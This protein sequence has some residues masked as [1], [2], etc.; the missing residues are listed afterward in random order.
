MFTVISRIHLT[1][2]NTTNYPIALSNGKYGGIDRNK[3][4]DRG[5]SKLQK[6]NCGW[7]PRKEGIVD[8][9]CT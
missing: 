6:S 4:C 5:L 9:N 7:E 2:I 3:K 1:R 8:P